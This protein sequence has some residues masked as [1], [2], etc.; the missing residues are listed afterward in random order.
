MDFSNPDKWQLVYLQSFSGQYFG[1]LQLP[2]ATF[3]TPEI[4]QQVIRL[5]VSSTESR[6]NWVFAGNVSQIVPAGGVASAVQ[7]FSLTLNQDRVIFWE[8]FTPYVLRFQLPKYFTQATI[9][10]FGFTGAL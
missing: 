5:K 10:I 7:S 8:P 4:S 9:S 1:L 6:P 2:I 3:D